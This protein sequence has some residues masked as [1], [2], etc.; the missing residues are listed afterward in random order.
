[1]RK[2]WILLLVLIP[3]SALAHPA[4]AP[5]PPGGHTEDGCQPIISSLQLDNPDF[6]AAHKAYWHCRRELVVDELMTVA[7]CVGGNIEKA[8]VLGEDYL[9]SGSES[10]LIEYWNLI[11]AHPELD[12]L[13]SGDIQKNIDRANI[14]RDACELTRSIAGAVIQECAAKSAVYSRR[15]VA[16][17]NKKPVCRGSR[18]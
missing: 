12:Q 11:P 13:D 10:A 2:F 8:R 17:L 5:C 16:A 1:M 15:I 9:P 4:D 14:Q 3:A 6:F 7:K 18:R